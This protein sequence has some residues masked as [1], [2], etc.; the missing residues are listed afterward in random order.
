MKYMD[1]PIN[2]LLQKAFSKASIFVPMGRIKFEGKGYCYQLTPF[3]AKD[4]V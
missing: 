3:I 4:F 2:F 1:F